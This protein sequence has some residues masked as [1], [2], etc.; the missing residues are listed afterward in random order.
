MAK[1]EKELRFFGQI[2]PGLV[3]EKFPEIIELPMYVHE[4]EQDQP[5]TCYDFDHPNYIIGVN[6]KL[7]NAPLRAKRGAL[8]KELVNISR[9]TTDFW[10]YFK[11]EFLGCFSTRSAI[12][13][14]RKKDDML[15]AKDL[16][17]DLMEYA[18]FL[19]RE[20]GYNRN[21]ADG[22][23]LR[24]LRYRNSNRHIGVWLIQTRD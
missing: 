5:F 23:S 11:D 15:I 2:L 12:E 13:I 10:G 16:G 18:W 22:Y 4:F 3:K 17:N 8:A 9:Y 7:R 14:A 24:E 1:K 21:P 19:Q 20:C 6:A